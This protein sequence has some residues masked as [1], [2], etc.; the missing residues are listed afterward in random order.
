M[1]ISKPYMHTSAYMAG[2]GNPGYQWQANQKSTFDLI[3][4]WK[5]IALIGK[6]D[7]FENRKRILPW[8]GVE[9]IPDQREGT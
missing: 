4:Q 3:N 7:S 9:V 1:G 2:R 5:M 8:S 6:M